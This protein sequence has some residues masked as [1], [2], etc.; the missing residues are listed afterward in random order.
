MCVRAYWYRWGKKTGLRDPG[1]VKWR[2]D[3]GKVEADLKVIREMSAN[4]DLGIFGSP[5][6]FGEA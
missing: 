5:S 3:F 1:I 2:G 4:N 6:G